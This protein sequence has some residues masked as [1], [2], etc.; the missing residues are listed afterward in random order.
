MEERERVEGDCKG[1]LQKKTG[2]QPSRGYGLRFSEV[3]NIFIVGNNDEVLWEYI[4][5]S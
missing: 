4:N 5:I 3:N 1:N 2:V